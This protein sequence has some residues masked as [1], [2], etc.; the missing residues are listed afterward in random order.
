MKAAKARENRETRKGR[1]TFA[2]F[3]PFREFRGSKIFAHDREMYQ[4]QIDA[5]D[6]QID[7]LVYALPQGVD[8]G[9]D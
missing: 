9:G 2:A 1:I 6:A 4:R 3:A 5:T 7:A 8:G